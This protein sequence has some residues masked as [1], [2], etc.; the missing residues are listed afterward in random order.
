MNRSIRLL[1]T[2]LSTPAIV[3]GCDAS[4][5]DEAVADPRDVLEEKTTLNPDGF[6]V[7]FTAV[8][9]TA[10]KW[11]ALVLEAPAERQDDW[12]QLTLRKT[13][14]VGLP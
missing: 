7:T 12:F 5:T 9:A 6:G 13:L 11:P 4:P 14:R 8:T 10:K 3:V 2:L 1:L